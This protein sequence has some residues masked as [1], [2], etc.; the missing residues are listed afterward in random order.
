MLRAGPPFRSAPELFGG[1]GESRTA[2][3]LDDAAG[4]ASASPP[5]DKGM[6]EKSRACN[7]NRVT[8]E[9]TS[10]PNRKR[11]S[12]TD[13]HFSPARPTRPAPPRLA[14]AAQLRPTPRVPQAPGDGLVPALATLLHELVEL[15]DLFASAA[16]PARTG[17][18]GGRTVLP[19]PRGAASRFR[20]ARLGQPYRAAT[21]SRSMRSTTSRLSWA[22]PVNRWPWA[23]PIDPW[24]CPAWRCISAPG[25]SSSSTATPEPRASPSRARLQ[26]RAS[27]A[28]SP[29]PGA[30]SV[31]GRA[32]PGGG[33]IA[34]PPRRGAWTR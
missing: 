6:S 33:R 19:G 25:N 16:T 9:Y 21:L 3:E 20:L 8:A 13:H 4:A 11:S 2:V 1:G 32:G 27:R 28:R 23:T 29:R 30:A 31:H 7:F 12:S 10:T 17:P 18:G 15:L 5:I 22:T 34:P 14:R 26:T 24:A